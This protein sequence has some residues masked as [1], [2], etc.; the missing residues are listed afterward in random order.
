MKITVSIITLAVVLAY[1]GGLRVSLNPFK[2]SLDSPWLMVSAIAMF[3]AVYSHGVHYY[4]AGF[5][6]CKKQL[7]QLISDEKQKLERVSDDNK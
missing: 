3:V 6:N 5:Y 2:I 1:S 7:I 4:N